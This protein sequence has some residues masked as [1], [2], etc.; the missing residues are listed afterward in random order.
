MQNVIDTTISSTSG[1][2]V[3]EGTAFIEVSGPTILKDGEIIDQL[4]RVRLSRL[5]RRNDAIECEASM[6]MDAKDLRAA[7]H[8]FEAAAIASESW[9]HS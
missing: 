9:G 7:A 5:D 1:F 2:S 4:F 8:L 6:W 3:S